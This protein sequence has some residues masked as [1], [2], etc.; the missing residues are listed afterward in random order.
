VFFQHIL[1]YKFSKLLIYPTLL[2]LRVG[3]SEKYYLIKIINLQ[4]HTL[5]GAIKII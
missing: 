2:I 1:S 3:T 5:I 4:G